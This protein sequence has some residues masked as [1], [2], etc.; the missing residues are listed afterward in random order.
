MQISKTPALYP[1]PTGHRKDLN[2]RLRFRLWEFNSAA[3]GPGL[4]VLQWRRWWERGQ[5]REWARRHLNQ[6]MKFMYDFP[7]RYPPRIETVHTHHRKICSHQRPSQCNFEYGKRCRE[8]SAVIFKGHL[9]TPLWCSDYFAGNRKAAG[10]LAR[11]PYARLDTPRD[12]SSHRKHDKERRW[13]KR[14][15]VNA[16]DLE[17]CLNECE[18]RHG[19]RVKDDRSMDLG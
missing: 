17:R 3:V 16:D 12:R 2:R 9:W 14:R 7:V 18:E 10:H 5:R 1:R 19:S 13:H 11:S 8:I 15:Q 4:R 6:F